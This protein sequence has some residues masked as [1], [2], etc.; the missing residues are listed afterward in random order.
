M[1]TSKKQYDSTLGKQSLEYQYCP[2]FREVENALT[3]TQFQ[4]EGR[5]RKKREEIEKHRGPPNW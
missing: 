5:V 3:L 2:Y 1:S 4:K